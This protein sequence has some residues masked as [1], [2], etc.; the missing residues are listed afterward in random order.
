MTKKTI[1]S[2]ALSTL[3]LGFIMGML[4]AYSCWVSYQSAKVGHLDADS[5]MLECA[6]A[7]YVVWVAPNAYLSI[8]VYILG[9]A[10][11]FLRTIPMLLSIQSVDILPVRDYFDLDGFI[12]F[13]LFPAL[14][15]LVVR[16]LSHW[17]RFIWAKV[18][19]PLN[20]VE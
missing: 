15:T 13:P 12:S 5:I 14:I 4:S 18:A 19:K 16:R 7:I 9:H 8:A 11:G 10:M 20:R 1:I 6:V 17:V 2:K 3:V